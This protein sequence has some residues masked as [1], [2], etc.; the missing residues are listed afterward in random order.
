VIIIKKND[1]PKVL[2]DKQ[3]EAREKGLNPNEAY[4]LL[5][6]SAKKIVKKSLIAEQGRLCAYCMR[7][8]PDERKPGDVDL[9]ES[10][11]I[12]HWIPL[13]PQD[14]R[15]VGQALD[16]NNLLAVCSG[17]RGNKV[18][19]VIKKARLPATP[20]ARIVR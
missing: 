1:S 19:K 8:I 14:K 2:L 17:N 3:R 11:T 12:E 18:K 13:L 4:R 16:Y 10:V 7:R 6:G 20:S 15:D 5:D 9:I